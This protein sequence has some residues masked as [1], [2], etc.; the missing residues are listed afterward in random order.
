[1]NAQLSLALPAVKTSSNTVVVN[2]RC[3]LRIEENQRVVV[4]GGLPV[5]HYQAEDGVAEAYAMVF[6][7][8]SG[9][10]RQKEVARAFGRSDRPVRR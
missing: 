10:A 3:L 2:A 7:V 5:H 1:M 9:F 6:L 4:V 8:E